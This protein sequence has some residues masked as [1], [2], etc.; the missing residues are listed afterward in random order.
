VK[1]R[2]GTVFQWTK[3][4]GNGFRGFFIPSFSNTGTKAKK[5]KYF[6]APQSSVLSPL[7]YFLSFFLSFF[8]CSPTAILHCKETS[9]DRAV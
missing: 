6:M 3:F 1:G 4:F 9:S 8:P 5:E 7:S 2:V